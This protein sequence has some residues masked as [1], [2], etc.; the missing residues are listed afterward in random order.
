[1]GDKRYNSIRSGP[2]TPGET[3]IGTHWTG[4]RVRPRTGLDTVEEREE[5]MHYPESNPG[6]PASTRR[7]TY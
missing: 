7:Y 5:K 3:A 4:G 2:C 1:M 6:R